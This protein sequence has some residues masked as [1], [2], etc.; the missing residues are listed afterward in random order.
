MKMQMFIQPDWPAPSNIKAY[1]TLRHSGISQPPYDLLNLGIHVGDE[2]ANV[3]KN[4]LLLK[5]L[6]QLPSEPIWIQQQHSNIAVLATDENR[7]KT[8]DAS[9]TKES[10][11]ICVVL[12][13]DCLPILL[14]NREGTMVSAIHAGWRGLSNGIILQTLSAINMPDADILA[15]L[16]PAIS[17]ICF[18]VGEEVRNL[19]I[20]IDPETKNAFTPTKRGRWLGDLYAI[21]RLQLKKQGITSIYGGEH[22][23]Y[24][25]T[26]RFFSYRRDGITGRMASLIWIN[27]SRNND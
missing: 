20:D 16:G 24:S 2:I 22:C 5:Q 11:T 7:N 26:K 19:F 18:E 9:F 25:D 6:L 3:A 13:A 8:A 23:T 21:A 4:R 15:W 17:P 12:T 27:D 1:S 10:N 14:C